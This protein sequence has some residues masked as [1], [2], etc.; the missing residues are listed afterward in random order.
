[1]ATTFVKQMLNK[2]IQQASDN[3]LE[4]ALLDF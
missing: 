2:K 3:E 1:M 4:C